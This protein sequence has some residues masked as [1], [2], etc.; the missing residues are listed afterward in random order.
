MLL[1]FMPTTSLITDD[2]IARKL[3]CELSDV[4]YVKSIA[5]AYDGLCCLF[6]DGGGGVQLVAPRGRE[7]EL[8]LLVNDLVEELRV[9]RTTTS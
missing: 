3:E 1:S 4:V 2:L 9:R 8:D 6:S 5:S 7:A